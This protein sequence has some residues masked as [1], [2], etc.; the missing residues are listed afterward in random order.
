MYGACITNFVESFGKGANTT[1]TK[2][3]NNTYNNKRNRGFCLGRRDGGNNVAQKRND[4][5]MKIQKNWG[6]GGE[7]TVSK[8]DCTN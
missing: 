3:H 1:N 5:N 6:G 8:K 4:K 7:G 2:G